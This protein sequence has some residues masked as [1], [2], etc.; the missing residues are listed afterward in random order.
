M[1]T[2]KAKEL[3]YI[4][5]EKFLKDI[6]NIYPELCDWIGVYFKASFLLNEN[7]TDLVLGPF[8]GE[9][10]D[11]IRIS[12]DKGFCGMAIREN[13]VVN[14][15]DVTKGDTHIA[16]SLETRSEIVIPLFNNDG[17]SFAE[18]DIDNNELNAFTKDIE[19]NL[20]K[21]CKDFPPYQEK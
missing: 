12:I 5:V 17:E 3:Y 14:I 2:K 4:Q 19:E 8:I 20:I 18:L 15:T 9:P 16:C 1:V 21:L 11:H 13:R 10:T 7:S 6:K